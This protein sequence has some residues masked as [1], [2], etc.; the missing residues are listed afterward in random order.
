MRML[1]P[2]R[3]SALS[4]LAC[5]DLRRHARGSR[6]AEHA[7]G[8]QRRHCGRIKALPCV[9]GVGSTC[10][11]RRSQCC[12]VARGTVGA[13]RGHDQSMQLAGGARLRTAD[14]CALDAR[15]L[16]RRTC[17][18]LRRS[19][20]FWRCGVGG[21]LDGP[22]AVLRDTGGL[23]AHEEARLLP[24][25]ALAPRRPRLVLIQSPICILRHAERARLHGGQ[26]RQKD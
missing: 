20:A 14:G 16:A 18:P 2:W 5:R 24:T 26:G 15:P 6:K 4:E 19:G 11:G 17:A 3:Q 10:D 22:P 8:E 9:K 12:W 21:G 1:S 13:A 7:G 23:S 25:T